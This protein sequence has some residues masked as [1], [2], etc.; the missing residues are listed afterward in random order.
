MKTK[1]K[2]LTPNNCEDC[3]HVKY[4]WAGTIRC[5]DYCGKDYEHKCGSDNN[6]KCF[7]PKKEYEKYYV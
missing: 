3:K 7:V 5:Y 6:F 4:A 2:K 1:I